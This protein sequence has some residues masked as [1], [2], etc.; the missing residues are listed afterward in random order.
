MTHEN[1]A[2]TQVERLHPYIEVA[3]VGGEGVSAGPGVR[4]LVGVAGETA[5]PLPVEVGNH[6][7]PQKRR[8]DVAVHEHDRDA[9]PFVGVGHGAPEDVHPLLGDGGDGRDRRTLRGR[10]EQRDVVEQRAHGGEGGTNDVHPLE[11]VVPAG[12]SDAGLELALGDDVGHVVDGE[13][14]VGGAAIKEH[15][16]ALLDGRPVSGSAVEAVARWAVKT[17]LLEQHP[18]AH[19]AELPNHARSSRRKL[20]NLLFA[21]QA[22]GQLPPELSLWCTLTSQEE[23]GPDTPDEVVLLPRLH[24]AGQAPV[25][26]EFSAFGY[27]MA[28]GRQ[29]A[30]QLLRHPYVEVEH[31]FEAANLATRLWPEPPTTLDPAAMATLGIQG[32]RNWDRAFC[33]GG[34]VT[35]LNLIRMARSAP[36]RGLISPRITVREPGPGGRVL[37][38]RRQEGQVR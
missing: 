15:V 30:L 21:M 12:R 17:L 25:A 9:S 19:D 27:G 24:V 34:C 22:T 29:L 3:G 28:D 6:I 38:E 20:D 7:A 2:V 1:N 18:E 10:R 11:V 32:T 8:H 23:S 33:T 4:E 16:R 13:E 36:W 31:P 5:R 35:D 14:V 37:T 26:F